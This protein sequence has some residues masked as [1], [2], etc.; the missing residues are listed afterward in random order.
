MAAAP[1]RRAA[2]RPGHAALEAADGR[3]R[4]ARLPL[5]EP[6]R[7]RCD[8]AGARRRV[9][10]PR[11]PSDD[12][13]HDPR[14]V[15]A[16]RP[17]PQ[18]AP[19]RP[20]GR[21]ALLPLRIRARRARRPAP[22]PARRPGRPLLLLRAADPERGPGRPLHPLEPLPARPRPQLRPRAPGL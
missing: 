4:A 16:L 14:R 19:A 6:R 9:L 11:L 22:G 18:P 3:Q 5:R 10:L 2:H 12:H 7:G 1:Q 15:G 8:P 13:R 21:A 17:A 20:G